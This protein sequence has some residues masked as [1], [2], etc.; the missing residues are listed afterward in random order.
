MCWEEPAKA[1]EI[2][3]SFKFLRNQELPEVYNP[4]RNMIRVLFLKEITLMVMVNRLDREKI[5][6]LFYK[7]NP[8]K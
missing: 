2:W 8:A 3:S 4:V 1:I 5:E 6:I 7:I